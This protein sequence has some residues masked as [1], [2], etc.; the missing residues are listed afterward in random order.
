MK[1][2]RMLKLAHNLINYSCRLQKGERVLIEATG[3]PEEFV[4]ALID[5]AYAAGGIPLVQINQPKVQRALL[6][7]CN[8][9]QMDLM[10][11]YDS[12][13]MKDCQAYI[14]VRGGENAFEQSDVPGEKKMLYGLNYAEKVHS[15]I[16][17]PETKWVVLRYPLPAM[18][19]Q[20]N[21]S[22]EA[23]EDFYFDVCTM[24]YAKMSRAMD[25]LVKR[26]E[27]TDQVHIV[28]PGTDL[29]FSI[30]GMPAI[31]CAGELNIPDGE[32]FSAP[33]KDSVNGVLTY[34]AP[35]LYQ[36]VRH[37]NVK[38]TFKD[39]KIIDQDGSA[40]EA[41]K[42]VFDTDPGARYVG[43][44][45]IGVN[46]FITKAMLDTLFDEKIAGSF[47]FTPGNCYDECPNG[48]KSAIHWDLVCIQT[49]EFG[50]GEMYFDGELIR[51]DGL[52]VPADLQCLN[53]EQLK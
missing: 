31:K 34:T 29:T 26:M 49:P 9:E 17:V 53:P 18:A 36:G 19:Q 51:K 23:F 41:L 4:C 52:F 21:M 8:E 37:E 42:A 6:M 43:E 15:K 11:K 28:G 32:V 39:G 50:G 3:I 46:P 24:D 5:E 47:H 45:A 40:P 2:P 38:L 44:F 48:N 30:K 13:R 10:A 33:I 7:G 22:T 35:S 20:A 25:A 1:D 16:R 27:S 12:L 14:G